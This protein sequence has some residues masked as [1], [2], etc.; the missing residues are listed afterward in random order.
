MEETAAKVS[1]RFYLK[2]IAFLRPKQ[3]VEEMLM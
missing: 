1:S 3:F 2:Y